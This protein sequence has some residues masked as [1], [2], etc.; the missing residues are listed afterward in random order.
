MEEHE[1]TRSTW[2]TVCVTTIPGN[3]TNGA[4]KIQY[5]AK[6]DANNVI[7]ET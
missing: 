7:A 5:R 4:K 2:M 6:K 3:S 1:R